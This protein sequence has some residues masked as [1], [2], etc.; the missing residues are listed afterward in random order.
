VPFRPFHPQHP[1][2][3]STFS[4][5][6]PVVHTFAGPL[7]YP[8]GRPR[9]PITNT[10]I[11]DYASKVCILYGWR[12]HR[13]KKNLGKFALQLRILHLGPYYE[14]RPPA[15]L[16]PTPP[17]EALSRAR[18]LFPFIA[19]PALTLTSSPSLC[20]WVLSL[21]IAP[22]LACLRLACL[23]RGRSLVSTQ[24]SS[25]LLRSRSAHACLPCLALSFFICTHPSCHALP[26]SRPSPG[27]A[28]NHSLA[29]AYTH[30]NR[31]APNSALSLCI[32]G[33]G[34]A[35]PLPYYRRGDWMGSGGDSADTS[36]TG[37]RRGVWMRLSTQLGGEIKRAMDTGNGQA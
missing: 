12:Q 28:G 33:I 18:F 4:R 15:T 1:D 37:W 30:E 19:L 6:S 9:F 21:V 24:H 23:S 29:H 8:F 32:S 10:S 34:P 7:L 11:S 27:I 25:L 14:T 13:V 35:I 26:G 31:R 22:A 3:V 20:P 16:E 36:S 2:P 17:L 5:N